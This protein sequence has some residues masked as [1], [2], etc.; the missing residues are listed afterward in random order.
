ML[1]ILAKH[2]GSRKPS[3]WR[4]D[5][6][7]ITKEAAE[8]KIRAIR[9]EILKAAIDADFTE[10]REKIIRAKFEE[11][12]KKESDCSSAKRGGDLGKFGRKK[13]QPAFEE[14]SFGLKVNEMS[15]LVETNSGIHIILRIL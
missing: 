9:K 12:A 15:D 8:E 11:I 10:S 13:M 1:H 7:V 2:A 4:Q 3:S 5:P 6:I 14:A